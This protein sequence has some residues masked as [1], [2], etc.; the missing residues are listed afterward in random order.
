MTQFFTSESEE[1]S[2][3]KIAES[4]YKDGYDLRHM[5]S[6]STSVFVKD[7]LINLY[8]KLTGEEL[9]VIAPI[10]VK[11]KAKLDFELKRCKMMLIAD[12]IATVGNTAKFIM[13]PYSGN[14]CAL[15]VV[16]WL[17]FI[18]SSVVMLVAAKRDS[19]VEE[20]MYNRETINKRWQELLNTTNIV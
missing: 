7:M 14:P 18:H 17:S 16:Q 8:L 1:L 11:E 6:M 4:M 5:T 3:A 15:N 13:P 9:S 20:A 10:A 2:I 19:T 12:S